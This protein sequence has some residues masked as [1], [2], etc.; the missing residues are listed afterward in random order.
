MLWLLFHRVEAN[1]NT[2]YLRGWRV[3][4]LRAPQV[5]HVV[6]TSEAWCPRGLSAPASFPCWDSVK[7]EGGRVEK[8]SEENSV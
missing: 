4:R 6:L 7:G 1:S 8:R 3:P 2:F 5:P